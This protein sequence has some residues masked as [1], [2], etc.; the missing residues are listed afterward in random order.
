MIR[1]NKF[2]ALCGVASRR[3]CDELIT[4]GKVKVNE[5]VQKSLGTIINEIKDKVEFDSQIVCLPK[6]FKY[7]KMNKPKGYICSKSDVNGRKTV[8]DLIQS[9]VRLFTIGR[10]DYNTEGLLLFTNDG[11]LAQKLA[12]P[13]FEIQKIYIAKIEGQLKESDLAVLRAGVVIDGEK[14]PS[15][16]V[17]IVEITKQWTRL[18]IKLKEGKNHQIK[19]MFEGIGKNLIFLKRIQI[20]DVK[21]GGLERGKFKELTIEELNGLLKI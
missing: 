12:H 15:A 20:G 7:F 5:K 2:L 8:Y 9:D 14:L 1:L 11:D 6:S 16:K 21:L 13:K 3:K 4:L 18:Q 10:L 19:K 17:E